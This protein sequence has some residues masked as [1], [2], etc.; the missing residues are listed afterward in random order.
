MTQVVDKTKSVCS[1]KLLL[2]V[3]QTDSYGYLRTL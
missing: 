1:V 2:T 3:P